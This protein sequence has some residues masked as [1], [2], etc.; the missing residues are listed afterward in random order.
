MTAFSYV[1]Q[2]NGHPAMVFLDNVAYIERLSDN[3]IRIHFM[4]NVGYMDT[5]TT[6]KEIFEKIFVV[7][8]LAANGPQTETVEQPTQD[9]E[10]QLETPTDETK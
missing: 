2:L 3:V 6:E 10:I 9:E 4:G 7:E 5:H 1:V 8:Y